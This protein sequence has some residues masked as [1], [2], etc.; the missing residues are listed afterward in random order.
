[1]LRKDILLRISYRAGDRLADRICNLPLP[2]YGRR[3]LLVALKLQA[4]RYHF[5][6]ALAT[7]IGSSAP[8]PKPPRRNL[9]FRRHSTIAERELRLRAR[10]IILPRRLCNRRRVHKRDRRSVRVARC[11]S[12]TPFRNYVRGRLVPSLAS[13]PRKMRGLALQCLIFLRRPTEAQRNARKMPARNGLPTDSTRIPVR[14]LR[15]QVRRRVDAL[16]PWRGLARLGRCALENL[17]M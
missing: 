10:Q 17:W 4:R 12:R 11:F 15:R 6:H 1:M 14:K 9:D 7:V 8:A 2:T 3:K 16:R 13:V 5:V